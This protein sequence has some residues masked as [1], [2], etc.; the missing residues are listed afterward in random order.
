MAKK[1]PLEIVIGATDKAS[2]AIKKIT[3]RVDRINEPF[4]RLSKNM[5]KLTDATGLAKVGTSLAAVGSAAVTTAKRIAVGFTAATAAVSLFTYRTAMA[6]DNIGD[7][8][9]RL[10]ISTDALQAWTY[11]FEQADVAPEALNSSLDTLNKNLG[12][13]KI[14]MGKSVKIF[15]GLGLDPKKFKTVDQLLPALAEKLSRI[16][17]P[18][19]RAAIANRLLGD[20]GAQ[21]A[22]KLAEGPQAL[23]DMEAAARKASAVMDGSVIESAGVLDMRLKSLRATFAGVTGNAMGKLYPALIKI[24]EGLQAAIVK[25]QPQINAFAQRFA[26]GIP[27]ALDKTAQAFSQISAAVSPLIDFVGTLFEIFGAGNTILATFAVV[28]GGQLIVALFNL[29]VALAG[30]G[31]TMTAAFAAPALIIAGV[32]AAVAAGWYLYKNWDRV[33]GY[34][35]KMFTD[36]RDGLAIIWNSIKTTAVEAFDWIY[37]KLQYHPLA[38]IFKGMQWGIGKLGA[39]GGSAQTPTMAPAIGAGAQSARRDQVEVKIDLSNLP[40]GTRTSATASDGVGFDLQRG[41]AMPG[42][43]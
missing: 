31:V 42:V 20:A 41:Y 22:V 13:A 37:S 24:A 4:S 8:A 12:L 19:K 18:A 7:T 21:M 10:N 27:S 35:K 32:I 36:L 14:G 11:G 3:D 23:R 5:G 26:D 25:Y 1:F 15:A 38:L 40:P 17:D 6:A 9:Q 16:S 33:V 29:G 2:A 28:V 30:L 34:F 39:L 43:N